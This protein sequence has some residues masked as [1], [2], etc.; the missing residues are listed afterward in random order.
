MSATNDAATPTPSDSLQVGLAD[1]LCGLGL[2]IGVIA[3]YAFI[4]LTPT[5]LAHHGLLLEALN[6][7]VAAII[8]G[9]AF[10]HEGRASLTLVV[11]APLCTVVLYDVFFW[12][13][14]RLWG[15]KVTAFYTRQ[16]PR[17]ARWL[18]RSERLVRKRGFW[19]LVVSNYLPI[20][21]PLIFLACGVSGMSLGVFIL[22]DA[23]GILLYEALLVSLGW[24][25]GHPAIHV[26]NEISHYSLYITV[27]LIAVIMLTAARNVHRA[28]KTSTDEADPAP[29]PSVAI[30][31]D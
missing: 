18:D 14:G 20:P 2:A 16:N 26:V 11:L 9:G 21:N 27:G 10:A 17:A 7:S 23:I 6:G 22:G 3:S 29:L 13:A 5:L 15:E 24:Q 1:V 28:S 19:A 25:I 4:P 31:T 8:T 30:P 12:W